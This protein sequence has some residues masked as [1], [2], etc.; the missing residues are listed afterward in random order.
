MWWRLSRAEFEKGQA[1]GNRKAMR[2]LVRSGRRPGLLAFRNGEPVGWCAV[3]PREEFAVLERSRVL[4]RLDDRPVWSIVCLYVHPRFR[5]QGVAGRLVR[6]AVEYAAKR[7]ARTVEAYPTRPRGGRLPP[8]SSFMGVPSLF[9][10]EGFRECARP[11]ESRLIVR[12]DIG[13]GRRRRGNGIERE[14]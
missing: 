3:A 11:S 12:L 13:S 1:G 8:V 6:A 7:G 14:G 4:K 2:A 10:R 9:A 5:G